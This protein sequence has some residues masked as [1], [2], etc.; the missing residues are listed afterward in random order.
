MASTLTDMGK[1]N[2]Q[3][4]G[5]Y[6]HLVDERN[7]D[8][9][10][11]NLV[12]LTIEK[13]YIASVANIIGTDLS[14][15]KIIRKGRFACS[16]MQVSRDKK[17]PVAMYDND[18]PAIISP[19]YPMFEVNDDEELMPEYLNMYLMREE[20]DREAVFYA[21]GGVRGSLEW[22]D[23]MA[24]QMPIPDIAEQRR[25]V[26]DYQAIEKRI[27]NNNRLIQK[28]EETA[29]TI[30]YHTFVENINSENLPDGWKKTLLF[31]IS[32]VIYG[33]PFNA[34][35]F[36]EDNTFNPVIRIRDIVD[37][38]TY[39]F[40]SEEVDNKYHIHDGDL[41][42]GMDGNFHM[43]IWSGGFALQNQRIVRFFP[44]DSNNISVLQIYFSI[45]PIIEALERTV[46]GTTV[47][48][49]GDKDLK[50]IDII[51]ASYNEQREVTR[52]LNIFEEEILSFKKENLLL[53]NMQN[54]ILSK[55]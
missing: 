11:S 43:T 53:R 4:I 10:I 8:L 47:T 54:L 30:Y 22:D 41:L 37:N 12:G 20:F 29:H 55:I 35:L 14:K 40:T 19:A 26:A 50:P 1:A 51:V 7:S 46:E 31:D 49:L 23:F 5:K 45:R 36:T 25:I 17:M 39:T 44:K 27:E 6:V 24:M 3:P 9:G 18:E 38:R 34:D 33:Y 52:K 32:N 15:Y 28:L 2:L 21:V 42:V 48:H 13:R 16:L